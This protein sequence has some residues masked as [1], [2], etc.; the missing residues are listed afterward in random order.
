LKNFYLLLGLTLVAP[1]PLSGASFDHSLWD[2]VLKSYVNEIG[3][4]DYAAIKANPRDLTQYIRL[5]GESSP[6]NQMD[7]FPSPAHELAYWMNAYNAFVVKGVVDNYPTKSVR[8]LGILYGFFRRKDYT[9]GGVKLSLLSLENDIIRKKYSEPRI[10]FGI[11]CASL[12][13][14]MLSREAFTGGKLEEQLDQLTRKFLKERRNFTLDAAS[15]E[16]TLS[17]IFDWYR[18]DFENPTGTGAT[19]Q[20][21][22]DF[23]RRYADPSR[24]Q[25]L[26][27]LKQPK[28]K[29]YDYDWSINEIGS[30]ARSKSPYERELV[31]PTIF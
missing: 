4:V 10:H 9:S 13:C 25:V 17:K 16:L 29:F 11:V 28:I 31:K 24:L 5:L 2:Q 12:S 7:Q 3:E 15:N 22:L 8:D 27:S 21:L 6:A 30:R 26:N 1:L 18:K 20:T 23:I 14:P 19:K